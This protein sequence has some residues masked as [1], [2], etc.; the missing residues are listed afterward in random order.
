MYVLIKLT[1]LKAPICCWFGYRQIQMEL[2]VRLYKYVSG[3][4]H[5]VKIKAKEKGGLD[6]RCHMGKM[7]TQHHSDPVEY[8]V[9]TPLNQ[10]WTL[11]HII[12]HQWESCCRESCWLM[13]TECLQGVIV[14]TPADNCVKAG[15]TCMREGM[16][17]STP[18]PLLTT[19]DGQQYEGAAVIIKAVTSFFD[20]YP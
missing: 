15:D 2:I 1:Y 5:H 6:R 14:L 3:K 11:M 10:W 7:L 18:S 20:R 9:A 4:T 16:W 8:P 17:L 12:G 19:V 13:G